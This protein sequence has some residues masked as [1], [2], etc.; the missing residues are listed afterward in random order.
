MGDSMAFNIETIIKNALMQLP[1]TDEINITHFCPYE[2]EFHIE[3]LND[4]CRR[5]HSFLN[6]SFKEMNERAK[7]DGRHF[8]A[9]NSRNLLTTID[10]IE[11]LID[12]LN[13]LNITLKLNKKY[14]N[15]IVFCKSFLKISNGSTIP[16]TYTDFHIDCYTPIFELTSSVFTSAKNVIFG[17]KTKPDIYITDGIDNRIEIANKTDGILIYDEPIN[18]GTVTIHDIKTWWQKDHP[19]NESFIGYLCEQLNEIEAKFCKAYY[20]YFSE[21]T[22]PALFSQ[23]HL[24]YDPKTI[25]QLVEI[26]GKKKRLTF[27]RMDFLILYNNYRIIIEID[28]VEHY[29][30]DGKPDPKKYSDQVAYD[31]KM[32]FLGYHIFRLG[33]H[34]LSKNFDMVVSDFLKSLRDNYFS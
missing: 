23:V 32:K 31:R 12:G 30:S 20:R 28:G 21:N 9:A 25:T 18:K 15:Q 1:D 10:I 14:Q 29:S 4:L 8:L 13:N 27:Q 19:V 2:Y 7:K 16:E 24:H 11:N 34:E 33:G 5:L 3:D 22:E 6:Q 17:S 26:E